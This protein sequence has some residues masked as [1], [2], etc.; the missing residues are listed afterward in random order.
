MQGP[1]LYQGKLR[2]SILQVSLPSY[3]D[4]EGLF[5]DKSLKVLEGSSVGDFPTVFLFAGTTTGSL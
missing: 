1:Q 3:M 5:H 2:T 4:A